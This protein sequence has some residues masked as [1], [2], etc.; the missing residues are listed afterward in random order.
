MRRAR[1]KPGAWRRM[2][3]PK[4]IEFIVINIIYM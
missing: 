2:E 4:K 1:A 3:K